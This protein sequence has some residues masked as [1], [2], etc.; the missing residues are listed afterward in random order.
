MTKRKIYLKYNFLIK[1]CLIKNKF[2]IICGGTGLYL[3]AAMYDY[4]F[5][6]EEE[7][8]EY[9]DFFEAE[10]RGKTYIVHWNIKCPKCHEYTVIKETYTLTNVEKEW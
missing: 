2:P 10:H 9:L 8:T 6:E 1:I 4:D 7:D 5:K 3:K